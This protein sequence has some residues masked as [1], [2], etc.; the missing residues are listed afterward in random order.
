MKKVYALLLTV[1]MMFSLTACSSANENS[2]SLSAPPLISTTDESLTSSDDSSVDN[3]TNGTSQTAPNSSSMSESSSDTSSSATESS[4]LEPSSSTLQSSSI[5]Q[6]TNTSQSS[7]AP[8]SSSISQASSASLS[9]SAPQSSST[10]Q[11]SSKPQSSSTPKS[12]SIPQS[13]LPVQTQPES[14][15][16]KVLVAYFSATNTTKGVAQRI[17]DALNADLYEIT[18]AVPYTSADLNYHDDNSRSTIE[19][20][21]PNSRP[22]ISGSVSNMEQYD[23]VFIGYPIW[24]AEAPRILNTFVESYSFSGKTVVPFCTSG[25]SGVGSSARNLERLANGG[26]WLS[27]TRLN[28]SASKTDIVRWINGLGLDITAE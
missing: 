16:S 11:S 10:P 9:S 18:P 5:A 1:L 27:G 12:S 3:S 14:E 8:Q 15:T 23:I 28:G 24:W 19:M 7:S 6:S 17:S 22:E 4:Q 2:G 20:N 21:D 13:S 26:Q 25:G